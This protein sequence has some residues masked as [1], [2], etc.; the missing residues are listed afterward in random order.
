MRKL[1]YIFSLLLL[2][3]AASAA[4]QPIVR[5]FSPQDYAAGTQ[6]WYLMQSQKG[7]IYAGNNYGLLEYDG[8]SWHIYGIWNSSAVHS[9]AEGPEG[10]LFVGGSNDFGLFRATRMVISSISPYPIAFRSNIAI[11]VKSIILLM[12]RD[13]SMCRRVITSLYV[14]KMAILK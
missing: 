12:M 1:S 10:E 3:L 13:L 4:W 14:R 9:I 2:S 11:S 8:R 7:W 5:N 6:N